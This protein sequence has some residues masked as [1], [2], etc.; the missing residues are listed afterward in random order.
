MKQRLAQK[1]LKYREKLIYSEVQIK[2]AED[3]LRVIE[4]RRAKRESKKTEKKTESEE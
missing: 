3:T 2:T 4:N 1:I